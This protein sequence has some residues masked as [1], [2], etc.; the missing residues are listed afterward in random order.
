MNTIYFG[1]GA[2]GIKNAAIKYF[3]KEPK[4]LSIAQAAILASLPKSPTKI[5]KDRKCT[6]KTENCASSDEKLWIYNRGRVQ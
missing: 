3:N 4:Q 5:F 1:Q 6:G 2:Y